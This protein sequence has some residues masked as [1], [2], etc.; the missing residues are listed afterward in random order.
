VSY[1]FV[2]HY[3]SLEIFEN[4]FRA[5]LALSKNKENDFKDVLKHLDIRQ[6]T[7]AIRLALAFGNVDKR[8]RCL[9]RCQDRLKELIQ[10][11]AIRYGITPE[12]ATFNE[13]YELTFS[14][15]YRSME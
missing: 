13:I 14:P 3:Q 6:L 15:G 1:D 2:E 12:G 9:I 8:V 4:R 7:V 5:F 10:V 11:A